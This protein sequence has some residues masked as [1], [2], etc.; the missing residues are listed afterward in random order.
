M[1]MDNRSSIEIQKA[2]KVEIVELAQAILDE[3]ISWA[4][5]CEK[6]CS[7]RD[8]AGIPSDYED[9]ME[10][11]IAWSDQML[12]GRYPAPGRGPALSEQ[13]IIDRWDP[14]LKEERGSHIRAACQRAI[15]HY[16]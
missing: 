6:I 1:S 11:L 3:S 16:S 8:E 12:D 2:L 14:Y 9:V 15:D 4:V 5:G 13:E 10:E 7:L